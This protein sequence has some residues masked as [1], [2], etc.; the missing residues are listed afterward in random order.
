MK[1]IVH[2][3]YGTADVLE[4]R[5][6]DTPTIGDDQMLV[7][8]HS[9]A[10]NPLDWHFMTGTPY[11]ARLTAGLRRPKQTVRGADLAGTVEAVGSAVTKFRPGD[12]VF[13]GAAG[14]FA[15]LVAVRETA[16]VPKPDTLSFD[17]AA[18]MPVAAITALQGLRDHG[19][20]GT[21]QSVLI[22]GAAGGVGTYAVQIARSLGAEVTGVCSSRNVDMVRSLGADHVIDYTSDDFADGTHRYDVILDNIGNRS[23]AECR[24]ALTPTGIY[25]IVGG[26]KSGNWIGPLKRPVMAKLR[27]LFCKQRAVMFIARET[28]E[29]LSKLVEMVESGRLRSV[30]DRR[31]PLSETADAIRHL[32]TGHAQGKIV[33]DVIDQPGAP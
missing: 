27:F 28:A 2:E 14:S 17:D 11:L 3:S 9:A 33:I 31:Y 8:V 18:A 5:D 29:E 6:I 12:E 23:L 24:R 4:L 19:H 22:N 21:G 13:G 20:L 26:P 30:I 10:V 15:E 16:V 25:V 1:A 32:A 7:R